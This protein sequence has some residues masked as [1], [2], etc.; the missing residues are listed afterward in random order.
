MT[1]ETSPKRGQRRA[2]PPVGATPMPRPQ[3]DN[4]LQ[5]ILEYSSTE[6]VITV[7][8][9]ED[10]EF[11]IRYKPLT[12]LGKSRCVAKATEYLTDSNPDTGAATVKA[13]F[14]LD[15]YKREALL[16]MVTHAP[17]TFNQS[18]IERLPEHVGMQLDGIIPDPF[19][20]SVEAGPMG[21]DTGSSS[22]S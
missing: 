2:A 7:W 6:S 19:S 17:F 12:W 11:E 4:L 10:T 3:K 18:V 21:K 15:I 14:H 1:T 13:T 8:L 9:D 22:E 5:A 16:A 20:A